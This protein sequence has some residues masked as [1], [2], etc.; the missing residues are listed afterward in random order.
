M[1][2]AVGETPSSNPDQGVD[3]NQ[4]AAQ[5]RVVRHPSDVIVGAYQGQDDQ[6]VRNRAG[7]TYVVSAGEDREA[8]DRAYN[9]ARLM[10]DAM[11]NQFDAS[12]PENSLRAGVAEIFKTRDA[13]FTGLEPDLAA[14]KVFQD[15]EGQLKA[16]YL[17]SGNTDMFIEN[18]RGVFRIPRPKPDTEGIFPG[19][20]NLSPGD[21]IIVASGGKKKLKQTDKLLE[22]AGNKKNVTSQSPED[23]VDYLH[24]KGVDDASL[25]IL[26][27]PRA[28]KSKQAS[29]VTGKVAQKLGLA[30]F[31]GSRSKDSASNQET[32]DEDKKRGRM[33]KLLGAAALG[34]GLLMS[35]K[36]RQEHRERKEQERLARQEAGASQPLSFSKARKESGLAAAP[37]W[38]ARDRWQARQ[39]RKG[40]RRVN[41]DN[42]DG[43][44]RGNKLLVAGLVAVAGYILL[45]ETGIGEAY[46]DFGDGLNRGFDPIPNWDVKNDFG[47]YVDVIGN[48][49]N[50]LGID[51]TSGNETG[52][53]DWFD[54]DVR[55]EANPDLDEPL[56]DI[57]IGEIDPDVDIDPP[58][59]DLD[60]D[61]DVDPNVTPDVDLTPPVD[62][63][64][65]AVQ[66]VFEVDPG[67][68][69]THYIHDRGHE[70][71]GESFTGAE[72]YQVYEKIEA[73]LN[74]GSLELTGSDE[75]V[76][77]R[78]SNGD[79]G[80]GVSDGRME[81]DAAIQNL[82]DQSIRE[83]EK[84]A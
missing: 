79:W 56:N 30:S 34:G 31:V 8:G 52:W 1:S 69:I 7:G 75:G 54:D 84:A 23:A 70:L 61:V 81:W 47:D 15:S 68:G 80:I 76:L 25:L 40:S 10:S 53:Q 28:E 67:E 83:V 45:K 42:Q 58:A 59:V 66:D 82:I 71:V 26:D 41:P 12:N 36:K 32:T 14:V 38:V 9:Y 21:R 43:S 72:S 51:I 63:P 62:V 73:E 3:P 39:D 19:V 64:E 18:E 2:A 33:G 20:M 35:K 29:G 48:D 11:D 13:T 49:G 46:M 50:K 27:V 37:V 16:A 44:R 65:V 77:Y 22:L 6:I 24:K 57:G 4:A 5:E 17:S 55:G 74:D 78:M 60:P